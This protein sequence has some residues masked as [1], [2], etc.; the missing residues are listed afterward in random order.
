MTKYS[1]MDINPEVAAVFDAYPDDIKPKL[2]FLRKLILDT[3][4]SIG[5]V[6]EL[7][8]TLK[9]GE[10]SYLTPKTKSGSTIRIAWKKSQADQYSLFFKCTANLIPAFKERFP[11]KFNFGGNRS[12]DFHIHD[13]VPT[14][15]LSLC[16]ALA[17]TY[18]R[19]KKLT[20]TERWNMMEK[21]TSPF[22]EAVQGKGSAVRKGDDVQDDTV[23]TNP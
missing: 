13:E 2:M 19:N 22:T 23:N 14:K 20:F 15:E 7:E 3:A 8:E 17:L 4:A 21:I 11:E 6:G 18:H 12:L 5:D 9:W 16:I 1:N 10:P